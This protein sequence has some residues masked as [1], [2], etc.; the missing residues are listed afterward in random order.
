MTAQAG[1]AAF[2]RMN[3]SLDRESVRREM[4]ARR[5]SISSRDRTL[6]SE[7]FASIARR[8]GLLKPGLQLA[9]YLPYGSE[10]DPS[11]LLRCARKLRCAVHL[12]LITNYRRSQM[13]FVPY[14]QG[15]RLVRNRYGILE[16][17][18]RRL[19]SVSVRRLDVIFIP[20]VA[21]D[22]SGSRIGSGAGFYD[23]ALHHLRG[24]RTWRRPKLIGLAFDFQL[25]ERIQRQPW[26][27]PLDALLTEKNL[28]RF[29]PER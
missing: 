15:D 21:V 20:V 6:T 12:P 2:F 28:Y 14:D 3:S 1:S 22:R 17:L 26:D 4:R 7:R 18:A 24:S 25:I 11:A 27:V 10:A 29:L 16:P 9:L 19:D 23:R 5:R 8:S 13:R